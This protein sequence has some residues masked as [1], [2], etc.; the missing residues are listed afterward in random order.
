MSGAR[1]ERLTLKGAR[2]GFVR[3]GEEAPRMVLE[4]VDLSLG[5]GEARSLLGVSGVGKSLLSRLLIGLAPQGAQLGGTLAAEGDG[6]TRR[7]D[8]ATDCVGRP[9]V[10]PALAEA[11]GRRIAF[12]PQGGTRNLN[13]ARTV[14]QHLDRAR[15]R[16]GLD[17]DREADQALLREMGFDRPERVA[18]LRPAA[19]SEGM[20]RRALI[21]LA[22]VG[23]PDVL[24]ADEPTTGLDSER[25]GQLVRLLDAA[26]RRHGFGLLAVTHEIG[27]AAV[28][29]DEG[30]VLA[31][32]AVAET[33]TWSD[34]RPAGEPA[35]PASRALVDGWMWRGWE[36]P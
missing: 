9:P 4:D 17:A 7:F 18:T 8:L 32:G 34:G 33:L 10:V 6:G 2:V 31:G 14:G 16:A 30:L 1:L 22:L 23:A 25:R 11:W 19:L 15:R 21:A 36:A 24:V 12:V 27:D 35:H 5:R 28:L 20:A 13:P 3:P 29:S 26:R